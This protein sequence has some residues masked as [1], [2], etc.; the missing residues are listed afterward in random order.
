MQE[1]SVGH[2]KDHEVDETVLEPYRYLLDVPGKNVRGQ[3][4]DAF[5]L[6]FKIP[7]DKG[8]ISKG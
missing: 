4:V 5:S 1:Y 6:W 2:Y 7:A 3:L 8:S